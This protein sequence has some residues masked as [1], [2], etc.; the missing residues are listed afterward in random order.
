MIYD[1]TDF[2]LSITFEREDWRVGVGVNYPLS[3]RCVYTHSKLIAIMLYVRGYNAA[4][5]CRCNF[6]LYLGGV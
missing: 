6:F 4:F 5:L 1:K 2:F 3:K